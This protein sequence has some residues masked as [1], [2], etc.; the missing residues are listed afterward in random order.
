M[1][2]FH[3]PSINPFQI[4]QS[5]GG[6]GI[7]SGYLPNNYNQSYTPTWWSMA[8]HQ[9]LQYSDLTYLDILFG[10][11]MQSSPF[12]ASQVQKRTMPMRKRDFAFFVNGKE[13]KRMTAKYITNSIWFK[14]YIENIILSKF[15]GVRCFV[16]DKNKNNKITS[17]P[18][19]NIDIFNK[20]LRKVT[21]AYSEVV[22]AKDY[23]NMFFF[24]PSE[25][26]DTRLGLLLPISRMLMGIMEAYNN[27]SVVGLRFSYPMTTIGFMDN[28]PDAKAIA[29][30]I[31]NNLNPMSTPL[32]PFR[33]DMPSGGK[34]TY[35]VEVNSVTTQSYPDAFRVYKELINECRSEI[36]QL[37]TGGTLLGATEKNTNSEQLAT[38]HMNMYNDILEADL[39][40]VLSQFNAGDN[41]TKLAR[42]FGDDRLMIAELREIP[43]NT[44]PVDK[45]V[46][47]GDILSKMGMRFDKS[48]MAKVG[49]NESDINP[50]TNHKSWMKE[51]T[52]KLGAILGITK[53]SKTKPNNEAN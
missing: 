6:G 52:N 31:S 9:A 38:I 5:V 33:N 18:L 25:D 47:I 48:V 50:S 53:K 14:D 42:Y 40:F 4:P 28:N 36:M 37:I 20:G 46:K 32:L 27:W 1:A 39:D 26:Q 49:L 34:S 8:R 29:E 22:N 2:T 13:D 21:Y 30:E 15:Y 43:N 45:F 16:L 10:W 41:L 23:D 24:E 44:I 51:T 17:F 11:C 12:L 7:K 3:N 35:Q 19:R